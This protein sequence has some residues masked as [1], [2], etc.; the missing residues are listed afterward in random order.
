M[1]MKHAV[2]SLVVEI[3]MGTAC[4]LLGSQDLFNAVEALPADRRARI[5]L[6]G[7]A[8][9]QSCRKGPSVRINGVVLT[10]MTPDRLVG[11]INDNLS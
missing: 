2:K 6:R 5:D 3:C 10:E 4:H 11:V 9:L 8:C 1:L 7:V